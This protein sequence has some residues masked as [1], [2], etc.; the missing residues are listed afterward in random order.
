MS[1]KPQVMETPIAGAPAPEAD[2]LLELVLAEISRPPDTRNFDAFVA[3]FRQTESR[4]LLAV[5]LYGSLASRATAEA[6]SIPDFYLI[7]EDARWFTRARDRWLSRVLPP[8]T[9]HLHDAAGE[10][11]GRRCKYNVVDWRNFE[12]ETGSHARDLYHLGR[13]TKRVCLIWARD[14]GVCRDIAAAIASALRTLAP[15]ALAR[16]TTDF[17][18]DDFMRR[19][20][21]LSYEGEVRAEPADAKAA[22]LF[23]AA[24]NYYRAV[25]RILLRELVTRRRGQFWEPESGGEPDRYHQRR[26]PAL[27]AGELAATRVLLA[28]SRRRAVARWPKGVVLVDDWLEILLAK[29]KRT[30]GVDLELTPL[31]RR[32]PLIFGWRHFF[33]LRH[34]GKIR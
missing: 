4:G 20:L 14:D 15:H 6:S 9:Y 12:R 11:A 33:R 31:E 3:H 34:E 23:D 1:A 32:F 8:N 29:V 24:K 5:V 10:G 26:T 18:L 21:S 30:H 25:G 19:L 13:F 2:E 16:A 22:A 28:R 7:V 27:R 17:H